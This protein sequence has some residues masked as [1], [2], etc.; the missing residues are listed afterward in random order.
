MKDINIK[1]KFHRDEPKNCK[2][3]F[4][5]ITESRF[6]NRIESGKFNCWYTSYPSNGTWESDDEVSDN[7]VFEVVDLKYN[8]LFTESNSSLGALS[9]IGRKAKEI[10]GEYIKNFSLRSYKEWSKWLTGDMKMY[11]YN[12]Y[13]DN[14]LHYE[15]ELANK[16]IIGGY[17]HLGIEF[18]VVMEDMIHDICDKKWSSVHI[19]NNR[20]NNCEDICG[21]ILAS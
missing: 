11:G 7:V 17:K 4:K 15:Y 14:W 3:V 8:L 5:S 19:V 12:G 16:K 21:Y 6:F 10:S 1:V 2:T 20:N 18:S 13:R 9:S